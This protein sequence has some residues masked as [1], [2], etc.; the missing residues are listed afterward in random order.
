MGIIFFSVNVFAQTN[1]PPVSPSIAPTISP[2]II[3]L[4]VSPSATP[5]ITPPPS[6]TPV[7]TLNIVADFDGT[8]PPQLSW[9]PT[10]PL[11]PI[12]TSASPPSPVVTP[13]V[14]LAQDPVSPS[15]TISPPSVLGFFQDLGTRLTDGLGQL[16]NTIQDVFVSDKFNARVVKR[17]VRATEEPEIEIEGNSDNVLVEI[18]G[19]EDRRERAEYKKSSRNRRDIFQIKKPRSFK[20]GKYKVVLTKQN[21]PVIEQD[22]EWGV[23]AINTNKSIYLPNETA[24]MSFAV[25]DEKGM[26]VCDAVVKLVVK[27][28]KQKINEELSTENGRIIVNQECNLHVFSL[29]SDY[30]ASYNVKGVGVYHLELTAEIQNGTYRINDAIEVRENVPFDIDRTSST[31][32]YPPLDY[33]MNIFVK[34]NQDFSGVIEERVPAG[35]EVKDAYIQQLNKKTSNID[36]VNQME[37]NL[38]FETDPIKYASIEV[39]GEEKVIRYPANWQTGDVYKLSY[40]YNAPDISPQFYL[41]GPLKIGVFQEL[42]EW[43]LAIDAV[44]GSNLVTLGSTTDSQSYATASIT[45]TANALV[46]AWI[47]NTHASSANTVT[48]SG[49]GL[50]WV[51]IDTQLF[52]SNLRRLTL[53]RAMG[54]SPSAG[55]VTITVAGTSNTGAAWSITQ[56]TGVDTSGTNG[57]GAIVQSNKNTATGASSVTVTLTNAFSSTTNGTAAG[58]AASANTAINHDSGGG[59]AELGDAGYGTPA[60]RVESQWLATN[61]TTSVGTMSSGTS[62]MAGISVEIKSQITVSGNVYNFNTVSTQLTECDGSTANIALRANGTTFTASCVD[63][64]GAF[65]FTAVNAPAAGAGMV[66][67]IDNIGTDGALVIRYDGSGDST[68]NVFYDDSVTTTSDD[69][70][71]VDILDMDTYDNGN[72]GDIPYTATDAAT[73]TLVVNS[74]MEFL[75]KKASGVS[76]GSTVF[77]PGGTVTTNTTGGDLHVDDNSVAYLDTASNS[78]G[79]DVLVDTGGTLNIDGSTTITGGDI[80]LGGTGSV[81]TTTG[82]PTTTVSGAGTIGGGTGTLT[83]HNLSLSSTSTT[84]LNAPLTVNNDFT[85]GDASNAHTL[86]NETNDKTIDVNGSLVIATSST[87]TSSSSATQT[88]A[89]SYTNNGT[90]TEGTGTITLDGASAATLIS[91]CATLNSCTNKDFNNL[92]INKTSSTNTVTLSTNGLE[93]SSLLTITRG[94]LVQGT[95]DVRVEGSSAVSV[96]ANGIWSN[97]STGDL[98][99]GGSFDNSGSVTFQGNGASCGQTDDISITST[100]GGSARSW[101]GSGAFNMNDVS[102]QDQ[103]GSVAITVYSGASVSGNGANWTFNSVCPTILLSTTGTTIT[104]AVT[105]RYDSVMTTNQTTDYV[106]FKDR[107]EDDASPDTTHEFKGPCVVEASVTYCLRRDSARIT[108][109]LESTNNRVKVRVEGKL[110]NEASATYL[111]DGTNNVTVR[112]DYTFT[113]EGVYVENNSDFRSTGVGLDT[114]SGHNGYDW[115]AVYADV[116]DGAFDDTAN[117]NYGDGNTSTTIS[118]DGEFANTNTYFHMPGTGSSTYQDALVGVQYAG[119]YDLDPATTP[120]M[121]WNWDEAE[122]GTQD[123][124]TGQAQNFTT[125]GLHTAKWYF[126]MQPEANLDTE[127]ERESF[128]NDYRNS[129]Q[130]TYTTGSE[131]DDAPASPGLAFD[132]ANDFSLVGDITQINSVS[133]VTIMIWARRTVTTGKGVIFGKQTSAGGPGAD[134]VLIEDWD[135][136]SIYFDISNGGNSYG[137]VAIPPDTKWHHYALVYDGTLSGNSNRLKGYID[138]VQMTLSFGGAAIPATTTSNTTSFVIGQDGAAG[139]SFSNAVMDE[140]RVYNNALTQSQIQAEMFRQIDPATSNLV[141]YWRMNENTGQLLYDETSNNYDSTLGVNNGAASDDPTWSTGYVPDYQNEAENFH[142][143]NMSGNTS[144]TDLDGEGNASNSLNG[145]VTVGATTITATSTSGFADGGGSVTH[146][147]HIDGDKFSYTDINGSNQFTGVPSTGDNAVIGHATGAVVS[148]MNRHR[149]SFKL[150]NWRQNTVPSPITLEGSSLTSGTDYYA[151]MKPI[152]TSYFAQDLLFDAPLESTTVS[153]GSD[154]T[155]SGCSFVP[156]KYGMGLECDADN[157]DATASITSNVDFAKGAL[158]FWLR[159]KAAHT[160]GVRNTF[161]TFRTFGGDEFFLEKTTANALNWEIFDGTLG[162]NYTISSTDYFWTAGDWVH[163]RFEWD[164]SAAVADQQKIFI[165]GIEPTHTDDP[166]SDNYNG[167]LMTPT[168]FRLGNRDNTDT[169]ECNCTLDEFKVYDFNGSGDRATLAKLSE[170]GDTADSDEYLADSSNDYTFDF[171]DDDSGNRGE[172]VFIGSDSQFQGINIDLSTLGVGS[173]EDFQW[174]YW[175]GTAWINLTVAEGT[176]GA[177]EWKAD[178]NCN[179]TAPG[180]WFP[181]GVNGSPDLY[182]VRGHLE[183]GSYSTDPIEDAIKTDLITFQYL[184]NLSTNDQTFIIPSTGFDV[185]GTVYLGNESTTATTGN[186]GP[187]DSSTANLSLRVNGGTA[188]TTTC[189]SSNGTFTFTGVSASA[190]DTITIYSTHASLKANRVYVS[191]ASADTGQNLYLDAVAIGDEQDGTLNILDLADYDNDQNSGD[192]LFD[193]D[194]ATPDTL[195][196]DSGV[197]LHIHTADTFSPNGTVTTQ[198]T[199]GDFHLDDSATFDGN[200]NDE[201]VSI[202]DSIFIDTS[203]IYSA[204]SNTANALT[205]GNDFTNNGTFTHN[206]GRTVFNNSANTSILLYSANITFGDL[207]VTTAGKP[208]QFDNSE[209][210]TVAGALNIQGADCTTGR[211]FLDSD[212]DESQWDINATGSV[213][214]TY[215]DVEDSNAITALLATNSTESD[216]GSNTNWRVDRGSCADLSFSISDNI[217]GYG[218]LTATASRYAT[219]DAAGSASETEAHTLTAST[220]AP[221]GYIIN[222]QGDTLTATSGGYTISAIGASNTAP[223]VGNEQF[224]IRSAI[225]SGNGTVT[226]PYAASGFA[227]D[228]TGS[229]SDQ[230][231]SGIGDSTSTIYSLRYLGNITTATEARPYQATLTYTIS[232]TF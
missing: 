36:E 15:P 211:V 218:S 205:I 137:S 22:F 115:L 98:I 27:N 214:V 171:N 180:N 4:S 149:P 38:K 179:W 178:G 184:N 139:T 43:Q 177:C 2:T 120:T 84:T 230:L 59:W 164:D 68:G 85:I 157:E 107:D 50:T 58:F 8:P 156:A 106:V 228:A 21:Q 74:G 188:A 1:V 64:T 23:L 187:C 55:A 24:K 136:G 213:S 146:V 114:D 12:P 90:L 182:Y 217:I 209:R 103:N 124:I 75:V 126:L 142:T 216:Y 159:P 80:T 87:F 185:S 76:N 28:D 160:D 10:P 147:A 47:V 143:I 94:T 46:L 141:A 138:G 219:G 196:V 116:T 65:T 112:E 63:A 131:W 51:Q 162:I 220:N 231:A 150:R 41:L 166:E 129:D 26:M 192:M 31:R 224:G 181:Y 167:S 153:V 130:L 32:L 101:T 86:D 35:F 62:N 57:S 132:G 9:Q 158:E 73:D 79:R 53:F 93:V 155:N 108:T 118:A 29:K 165:N 33:P 232:G 44:S 151:A 34:A 7:P 127:A 195:T 161:F 30:E 82:T 105:D 140:G 11:T 152:T 227:Y 89:A 189:S 168:E 37:L 173:S 17:G 13:E 208:M 229:V 52:S 125:R 49:N 134:G 3:P 122:S 123:L 163:I 91:G 119:W 14:L 194:D 39:V 45:P 133:K 212:V 95:L 172:Y 201:A 193:A 198:G 110:M 175:N 148:Q 199:G 117:N 174:E 210:T 25:L 204:S 223:S 169:R 48:L 215:A 67:W 222:V 197:E 97:T 145:A 226:A 16:S 206:N 42:R 60:A 170:G 225:N 221:G 176:S 135:D 102:V 183:G 19:P 61:D 121:E 96:A 128:N 100:S 54:A 78:I 81:A 71:P 104:I 186:G 113:T 191:D 18:Q 40:T 20:P 6:I 56:Y 70:N 203:A 200:T 154:L 99:L 5:T 202:A 190:G 92:T 72:D 77:D 88:I 69:T 109:V 207:Y 83:F 111:T 66:L 144:T